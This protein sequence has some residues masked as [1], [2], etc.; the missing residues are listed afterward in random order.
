MMGDC[1]ICGMRMFDVKNGVCPA[2]REKPSGTEDEIEEVQQN[3]QKE[4]EISLVKRIILSVWD[5]L[6][7]IA[8]L[9]GHTGEDDQRFWF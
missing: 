6:F 3:A 7:L 2:C 1:K 9:L 8:G 4:S 5:V